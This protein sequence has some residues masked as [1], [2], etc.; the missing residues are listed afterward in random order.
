MAKYPTPISKVIKNFILYATAISV[1]FGGY[2]YFSDRAV[3]KALQDEKSMEYKSNIESRINR[4]ENKVFKD[5][6]SEIKG[7]KDSLK[8]PISN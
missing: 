6:D 7:L 1:L 5:S 4:L 8:N 3:D 2:K